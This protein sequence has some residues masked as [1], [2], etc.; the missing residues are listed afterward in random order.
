MSSAIKKILWSALL[1]LK[2]VLEKGLVQ[3]SLFI[4]NSLI[5]A[6]FSIEYF[7]N[8]I[9]L[10]LPKDLSYFF[11]E[12]SIELIL[13][14][15]IL[16]ASPFFLNIL[17]KLES[18]N[19]PSF[20]VLHAINVGFGE[21]VNHKAN[22][23]DNFYKHHINGTKSSNGI[24][25]EITQPD[26]QIAL[27]TQM[28]YHIFQSN[29]SD[30]K[31]KVRLVDIDNKIPVA[32]AA[33][34]PKERYPRTEISQ[35]KNKNSTIKQCLKKKDLVVIEDIVK[36]AKE[37]KY[38][39]SHDDENE[40]GSL[41]CFPIMHAPTKSHSYVVTV[42]ADKPFFIKEK[43]ELYSWILNQFSARMQL[44]HTLKLLKKE[45]RREEFTE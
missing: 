39:M 10:Y 12:N 22:R 13:I 34:A 25:H 37:N 45:A 15:I 30:I 7:R 41:L 42:S 32:W 19:L 33:Y 36:A 2:H 5:F 27:L 1:C 21:I 20:D 28:V 35:L 4:L 24:F 23:F 9:N 11:L 44:E 17:K 43:H 14:A 16:S 38:V 3:S 8:K 26:Q 18:T 29:Y 31:F 40:V 6:Y